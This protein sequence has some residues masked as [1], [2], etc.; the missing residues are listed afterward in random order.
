MSMKQILAAV[1]AV[2]A[3]INAVSYWIAL[4]KWS[5]GGENGAELVSASWSKPTSDVAV[6]LIAGC[7][8]QP[9]QA[10][11]FV[12]S[13]L[14]D[15]NV[16][17]VKYR[18]DRGCDMKLI[19]DQ[20]VEDI[21][22]NSYQNVLVVGCSIG[23]YVGRVCEAELGDRVHT[24][25]VNP[26]PD[27]SLLKTWAKVATRVGV[28]LGRLLTLVMGWGSQW[29]LYSDCGN[30]FSANF[31]V[32]QFWQ[33]GTCHDAPR[34]SDNLLGIIIAEADENGKGEDEFLQGR[35]AMQD[36][37]GSDVE[38]YS[39]TGVGHGNTVKGAT[40]YKAAWDELWKVAKPIVERGRW[41]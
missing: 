19:A 6:Y 27:S 4:A 21:E 23:D 7:G 17:Y 31:M 25:A 5:L 10:F 35:E 13:D 2:A 40:A 22:A 37:F 33:I 11:E 26:E 20:V 15:Y 39:A 38:I 24:I 16:I 18:P 30:T 34:V 36:Y 41:R 9:E 14:K 8:N 28:P 29:Q 3:L 12:Q 1:I 32:S